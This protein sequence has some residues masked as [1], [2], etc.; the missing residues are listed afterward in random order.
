M[1][2]GLLLG[3]A[4]LRGMYGAL[5]YISCVGYNFPLPALTDAIPGFNNLVVI[6]IANGN[7]KPMKYKYGC[8]CKASI[9]KRR[10]QVIY[11]LVREPDV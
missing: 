2:V 11:E 5:N 8:R 10:G 1:L 6:R 3:I 9:V 7:S 4:L